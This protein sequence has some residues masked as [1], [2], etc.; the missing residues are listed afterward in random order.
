[1][2]S[3]ENFMNEREKM[4]P[5]E[6]EFNVMRQAG[7]LGHFGDMVGLF[8][9]NT[10]ATVVHIVTG[11]EDPKCLKDKRDRLSANIDERTW[12]RPVHFFEE[13]LPSSFGT[14]DWAN[15]N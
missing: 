4:L 14:R 1:M 10:M 8:V 11:G 6:V 5:D 13:P 7:T 12:S 15:P 9:L 3:F 2:N